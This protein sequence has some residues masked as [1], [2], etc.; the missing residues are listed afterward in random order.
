MIAFLLSYGSAN[1]VVIYM[2]P[3]I[4]S[5][6]DTE[7]PSE[8]EVRPHTVLG[9]SA[10]LGIHVLWVF[11]LRTTVGDLLKSFSLLKGFSTGGIGSVI[12][13]GGVLGFEFLYC[14]IVIPT[15]ALRTRKMSRIRHGL[16]TEKVL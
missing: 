12:L 1:T 15:L 10:F 5:D 3:R 7:K 11:V 13:D 6:S 9:D 16:D 8:K 14:F 2:L 4:R